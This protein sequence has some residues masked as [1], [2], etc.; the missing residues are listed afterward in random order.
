MTLTPTV[1]Q[2]DLVPYGAD[3]PLAS[4]PVDLPEDEADIPPDNNDPDPEPEPEAQVIDVA[5]AAV[6][7]RDRQLQALC[8]AE[9][10]CAE[11]ESAWEEA[12][13][14]AK[15]KKE[16]FEVEVGKLRSLVRAL[17]S[18]PM[19]LFEHAAAEREQESEQEASDS[20]E[21]DAEY[22]PVA[23]ASGPGPDDDDSWRSVPLTEALQGCSEKV[24]NSLHEAGL[25]TVGDLADYTVDG[26]R[27]L[28]DISGIGAAKTARIEEAMVEFWARRN[29]GNRS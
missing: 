1:T 22:S 3:G 18:P 9:T 14:D 4:L 23:S 2:T 6:P 28:T 7:D 15:A 26:K 27:E 11:A 25:D 10:A 13:A 16:V 24:L 8:D 17:N 12:K 19:P 29:G 5:F 21:Q 20:Q